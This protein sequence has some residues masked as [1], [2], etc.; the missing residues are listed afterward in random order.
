MS[1]SWKIKKNT[2]IVILRTCNGNVIVLDYPYVIENQPCTNEGSTLHGVQTL[3][4]QSITQ[5][6]MGGNVIL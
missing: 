3:K 6:V 1:C 5:A 2:C 4:V